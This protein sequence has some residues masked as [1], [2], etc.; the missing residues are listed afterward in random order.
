MKHALG[1]MIIIVIACD[2]GRAWKYAKNDPMCYLVPVVIPSPSCISV[3]V[4]DKSFLLR[5]VCK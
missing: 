4:D 1:Y 5:I 2:T 3:K